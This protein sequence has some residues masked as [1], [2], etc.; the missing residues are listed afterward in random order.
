M[1]QA[2]NQYSE[3][4]STLLSQSKDSDI[5][6]PVKD[7]EKKS[8]CISRTNDTTLTLAHFLRK[9]EKFSDHDFQSRRLVVSYHRWVPE[10]KWANLTP[11]ESAC[12]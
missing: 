12:C 8:M 5:N 7:S 2:A 6:Q 10:T 1:Q 3:D 11:Y 4:F 9:N